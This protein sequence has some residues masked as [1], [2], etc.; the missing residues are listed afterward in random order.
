MHRTW[1]L[2]VAPAPIGV[3]MNIYFFLFV[4]DPLVNSFSAEF[5]HK[6]VANDLEV[7]GEVGFV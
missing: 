6:Y 7:I 1:I 4:A 2:E 5:L 3:D